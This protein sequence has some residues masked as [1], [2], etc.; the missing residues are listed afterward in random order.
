MSNMSF[1]GKF[2]I[3]KKIIVLIVLTSVLVL[4]TSLFFTLKNLKEELIS[5]NKNKISEIVE[6]VN[7]LM[8]GYAGKVKSGEMTLQDAQ[9]LAI[10][11]VDHI[12]YQGKNYV[13]I[14][15]YNDYMLSHPTLKGKVITDVADKNGIRFFHDGV[16]LAKDKGEGFISYYWIKQG[17]NPAKVFPKISYFKAYPQWKWVIATGVYVDEID[18]A[19]INTFLQILVFSIVVLVVVI[20]LMVF[21]ALKDIIKSMK[22]IT[23]DLEASAKDIEVA[24]SE[25][26]QVSEK[27]AAGSVQQSSSIQETSSTLEETSSMVQQNNENTK[28]AATLAKQSKDYA[29]ASN[30]KMNTMIDAMA[31]LQKSS[32][33]ISKIIK[34]IDEIA[35]QTNILSLNAAVEA[36]RAG[37][38]GKGF[39]VVAEEVRNLAKRS[40]QAAKETEVIIAKNITLSQ[41][42]VEITKDVQNSIV[43]IDSQSAKVSELI[44]EIAIATQEQSVGVGQI[45]K[46][47]AQM[48]MVINSNAQTA[49]ESLVASKKLYEQTY[50][51]DEI[52]KN[53]DEFIEGKK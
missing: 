17:G 1:W 10:S 9:K 7:D 41:T 29:S 14:T 37:E 24:S 16:V 25:L 12:T 26:E 52:V 19:V 6:V 2:S 38:A 46:A 22:A 44:D 40:A 30:I 34:V 21:T 23:T 8:D 43:E 13:W 42:G 39:A 15:D 47:I 45:N 53:L 51:M 4:S 18:T 32:G 36:A 49:E 28:Q 48:E 31:E 33:E 3:N 35:F 27:L 20:S 50:A 11:D 5:A